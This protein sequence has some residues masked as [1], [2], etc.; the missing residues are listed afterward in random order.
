MPLGQPTVP[1][2]LTPPG[3]P[4]SRF[5]SEARSVTLTGH[6]DRLTD[7]ASE[8]GPAPHHYVRASSSEYRL[9]ISL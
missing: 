8:P 9:L 5:D 3:P 6:S 1:T 2:A 4:P 7:R